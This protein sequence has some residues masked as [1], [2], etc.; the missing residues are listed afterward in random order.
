MPLPSAASR[1]KLH[2]RQIVIEG[3]RRDDGLWD[4]EGHLVDTKTYGFANIDRGQVEAGEPLHEMWLRLTIDETYVVRDVEASTDAAPFNLCPVI[5]PVFKELIGLSVGPGW[6]RAVRERVGGAKGCTHHVEM[7][8]PLATVA[9]Q[10]IRRDA[11]QNAGPPGTENG[12]RPR[13]LDTCH[14]LAS[15]GPVVKRDLPQFYTGAK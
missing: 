9:F 15:D 5:T 12:E 10:T 7:L 14:A 11:S 6:Q 1:S 13:I 4:I 3:Y 2:T 8:G